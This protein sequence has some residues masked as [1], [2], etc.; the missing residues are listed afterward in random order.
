ML[1]CWWVNVIDAIHK[2]TNVRIDLPSTP[3]IIFRRPSALQPEAWKVTKGERHEK[4][5]VGLTLPRHILLGKN[6]HG[7]FNSDTSAAA[8]PQERHSHMGKWV[9]TNTIQLLRN[10]AT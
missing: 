10:K 6:S 2:L 9:S 5:T 7:S 3:K 8:N 1:R 4:D